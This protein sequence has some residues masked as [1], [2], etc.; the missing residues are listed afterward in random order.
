MYLTCPIRK[1]LANYGICPESCR[2]KI[3]T[4]KL[5]QL[6]LTLEQFSCQLVSL[7]FQKL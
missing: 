4:T 1:K 2:N 5:H 3:R 7:V 6:Y